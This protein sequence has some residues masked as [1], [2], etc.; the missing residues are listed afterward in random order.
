MRRF[1]SLFIKPYIAYE[2]LLLVVMII[3][4]L[5]MTAPPFLIG[6]SIDSMIQKNYESA[7]WYVVLFA[8]ILVGRLL[9]DII[10][11]CLFTFVSQRIVIRAR[12]YVFDRM[13]CMDEGRRRELQS[14]GLVNRV[15]GDL[16]RVE[17]FLSRS[18]L[19]GVVDSLSMCFMLIA[20][21]WISPVMG[22]VSMCGL[23]LY[24]LV[25]KRMQSK[26][27]MST[28]ILKSHSDSLYQQIIFAVQSVL[29]IQA[30]GGIAYERRKLFSCSRKFHDSA[31]RGHVVGGTYA[32]LAQSIQAMMAVVIIGVGIGMHH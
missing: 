3:L 31:I 23:P 22:M 19:Q 28:V 15:Y 18:L 14:G 13:F 8:V 1:Y 32:V 25:I 4:T 30:L 16:G 7:L 10:I 6:F 2:V 27:A 21:M 11:I 24:V 20:I 26:I 9:L 12:T 29:P 5:A 17:S